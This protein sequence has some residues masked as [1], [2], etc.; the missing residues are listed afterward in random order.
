MN[1]EASAGAAREVF[2]RQEQQQA[3]TVEPKAKADEE[4]REKS[5]LAAAPKHSNDDAAAVRKADPGPDSGR[6]VDISV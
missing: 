2:Q 6:K 1:V 3:R 5:Q 4:G